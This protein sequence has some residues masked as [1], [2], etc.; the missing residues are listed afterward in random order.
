MEQHFTFQG[1]KF[2][3]AP[4]SSVP[5]GNGGDIPLREHLSM[6]DAE[7]EAA[8]AEWAATKPE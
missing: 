2:I 6:T 8:M 3:V 1:C 5:D 7:Y 4:D